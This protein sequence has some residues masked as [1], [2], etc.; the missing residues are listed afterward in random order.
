MDLCIKSHKWLFHMAPQCSAKSS[1]L[2]AVYT[3]CLV[4]NQKLT[5]SCILKP[6]EIRQQHTHATRVKLQKIRI[7][8]SMRV[9]TFA[10]PDL[11]LSYSPVCPAWS[12]RADDRY[13]R[14]CN[15][16]A[17]TRCVRGLQLRFQR[18]HRILRRSQRLG[19]HE[20]ASL[21][22]LLP[23]HAHAGLSSLLDDAL[24]IVDHG[25]PWAQ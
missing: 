3:L 4:Q 7:D 1:R 19:K 23:S 5:S 24:V 8:I 21:L 10:L 18:L 6:A 22:F 9:D 16:G 2:Y 14:G 17:V 25:M 13:G 15:C 20:P 12:G 11:L